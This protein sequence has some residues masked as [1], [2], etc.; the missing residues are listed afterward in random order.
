[1]MRRPPRSTLFPYT[2]LSRSGRAAI[3]PLSEFLSDRSNPEA[4]VTTA[5]L[6]IKEI[7][8]RHPEC[9]A[10]CIGILVRTL[11]PQAETDPSIGGF[12]VSALIDLQAVEAVDALRGAFHPGGGGIFVAWGPGNGRGAGG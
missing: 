7:A 11:E 3:P 2:T 12:A 5:L 1:M 4:A 9:R 10:E 8:A 6:G